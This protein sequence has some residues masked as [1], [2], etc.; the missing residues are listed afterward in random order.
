[1]P[2]Y[3]SIVGCCGLILFH[4]EVLWDKF[5]ISYMSFDMIDGEGWLAQDA[6]ILSL[7]RQADIAKHAF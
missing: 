2:Y 4:P 7:A 3:K 6:N 5:L 1:M